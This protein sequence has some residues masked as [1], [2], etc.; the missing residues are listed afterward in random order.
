MW[1]FDQ[2]LERTVALSE[3]AQLTYGELEAVGRRLAARIPARSLVFQLCTN[4]CGS[5]SSKPVLSF[6]P[7]K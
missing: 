7:V 2:Y 1:N 6:Q 5:R 4:S 3:T